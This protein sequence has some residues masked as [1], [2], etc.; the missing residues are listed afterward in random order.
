MDKINN[1]NNMS[2]EDLLNQ[3]LDFLKTQAIAFHKL[4]PDESPIKVLNMAFTSLRRINNPKKR[5][6]RGRKNKTLVVT[7][8]ATSRVTV[9]RAAKPAKRTERSSRKSAPEYINPRRFPKVYPYFADKAG[10]LLLNALD[11]DRFAND[12][13]ARY[14]TAM[15]TR[16]NV[17]AIVSCFR[18]EELSTMINKKV[19]LL[20]DY[21]YNEDNTVKSIE[22]LRKIKQLTKR[23]AKNET[24]RYLTCGHNTF[25]VAAHNLFVAEPK[26]HLSS[27]V[28][29]KFESLTYKLICNKRDVWELDITMRQCI[30]G[31]KPRLYNRGKF[32]FASRK[33][34]LGTYACQTLSKDGKSI[35]HK[36][37]F[38]TTKPI[39][40]FS[41]TAYPSH[42]RTDC[43]ELSFGLSFVKADMQQ[44][45]DVELINSSPVVFNN[46]DGV[47]LCEELSEDSDECSGFVLQR[48]D[49]TDD[50]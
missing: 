7:G 39:E 14:S 32:L 30:T 43:N 1:N 25:E 5:R 46:N 27:V 44:I 19:E 45:A 9:K 41:I 36:Y 29:D 10:H 24:A 16:E 42:K 8:T 2:F 4:A 21:K 38:Q 49:E 23:D 6:N 40:G 26:N 22:S 3:K 13:D 12:Y 15:N 37:N 31:N 35:L 20:F 48:P 28:T 50:L 34:T 17:F 11:D 33:A 18:F 47:I